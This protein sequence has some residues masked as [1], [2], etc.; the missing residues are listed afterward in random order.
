MVKRLIP[1]SSLARKRLGPSCF[2]DSLDVAGAQTRSLRPIREGNAIG[3]AA[4]VAD[5]YHARTDGFTSLAVAVGAIGVWAGFDRADPIVGL[6]ISIAIF[7]VLRGAAKQVYYR[8]MD[9][10][11]PALVDKVAA[12]AAAT[13]GVLGV[14]SVQVRW[15]GHRLAADVAIRVDGTLPVR[16]GH[17]IAEHVRDHLLEGVT[18]LHNINARR[19]RHRSRSASARPPAP[20]SRVSGCLRPT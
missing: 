4:L 2:L 13:P 17:D 14:G 5:G 16:D 9:A 20:L 8:L 1:A 12:V 19:S 18:A 15:L 10:V 6:G 7:A 11:E 3:S